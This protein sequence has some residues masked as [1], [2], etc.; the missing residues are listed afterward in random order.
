M[1]GQTVAEDSKVV[2]FGENEEALFALDAKKKNYL[3]QFTFVSFHHAFVFEYLQ[4]LLLVKIFQVLLALAFLLAE[5]ELGC[6][7][8]LLELL[9]LCC[10]HVDLILIFKKFP[11]QFS[12]TLDPLSLLA[13]QIIILVIFL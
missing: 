11:F 4:D 7:R 5:I 10:I 6:L 2:R 1:L 3:L 8:Q 13:R 12:A 9:Y